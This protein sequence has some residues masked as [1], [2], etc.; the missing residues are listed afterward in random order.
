MMK[1]T[2]SPELQAEAPL[3]QMRMP[4]SVPE[5]ENPV[6]SKMNNYKEDSFVER[7]VDNLMNNPTFYDEFMDEFKMMQQIVK[8][9]KKTKKAATAAIREKVLSEKRNA[10]LEKCR[11][12]VE[13]IFATNPAF[14]AP[15]DCSSKEDVMNLELEEIKTWIQSIK[16]AAKKEKEAVKEAKQ[17]AKKEKE[18]AKE[19]KQAAKKEKEMLA[20]NKLLEKL[21]KLIEQIDYAPEYDEETTGL[22]DLKLIH[23]RVKMLGQ[24]RKYSENVEDIPDYEDETIMHDKLKTLHARTKLINQYNNINPSDSKSFTELA[25]VELDEIKDM[26]KNAKEANDQ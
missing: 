13:H 15:K 14:R 7:T 6:V 10:E 21:P 23:S 24:L 22:S 12:V 20:R 3:T 26:I 19:A 8:E 1:S 16:E 5:P 18:A 17:A 25:N 11:S 2:Q 9:Y 4:K